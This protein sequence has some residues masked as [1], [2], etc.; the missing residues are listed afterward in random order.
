MTRNA[1]ASVTW[2]RWEGLAIFVFAVASYGKLNPH[3]SWLIFLIM[4]FVPDFV[5]ATYVWGPKQGALFY[6]ALHN[7]IGP[8]VLLSLVMFL[9]LDP[10]L[11]ATA[12]IWLAHS[13]FDR[14]AGYGLKY[15]DSFYHTHLGWIARKGKRL[16]HGGTPLQP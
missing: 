1:N 10:F 6:N 15:P 8:T 11:N 5:I 2:Q 4:F 7:Y 13:G 16:S 14:A 3:Y 9:G 12:L